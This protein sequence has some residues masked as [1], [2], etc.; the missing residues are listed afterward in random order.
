MTQ[1]LVDDPEPLNPDI[2]NQQDG[3]IQ[4]PY[5]WSPREYQTPAWMYF[6]NGGKRACICWHRRSGK[7]LFGINLIMNSIIQ[8]PGLYWHL[9]PYNTQAKKAIWNGATR[10]GRPF[11]S[12]FPKALVDKTRED[13]MLVKFKPTVGQD[14]KMRETGGTYQL[15]GVDEPDRLVGPNPVGVIFSEWSLMDPRVWHLIKPI[16][17]ENG[18]WALFIFTMRG[19]NHAYK[20][21]DAAKEK[22]S[23]FTQLL[24]V[25]DTYKLVPTGEIRKNKPV[26]VARPLITEEMIQEDRDEGI[27]ESTIQAE[28]YGNADAPVEGS[29]YGAIINWLEK[30]LGRIGNIP[31]DPKLPVHTSWDIGHDSTSITFFQAIGQELRIIDFYENQGEGLPHYVSILKEKQKDYGYMYELHF[32][33][34]DIEQREWAAGGKSKIATARSLG[35]KLITVA[36]HT[37]EDGIEE[38]RAMLKRCWFDRSKCQYLLE[39]LREYCK[40]WDEKNKVFK[41]K[42]LH[43]WA[44]HPADSIRQLAMGFRIRMQFR[45]N[46]K[47]QKKAVMDY[48]DL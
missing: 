23:W 4:V 5:N 15:M 16:L 28:Y 30:Q 9:F 20:M 13:D 34:H 21:M 18:G 36:H 10:D 29:Y 7:D 1:D 33:P 48:R 17:N 24:T 3:I 40:E 39:A 8:R 31:H 6:Q 45:R 27:P 41:E 14:G 47:V 2:A 12:H 19:R 11:L 43:N 26:Y 44:S 22:K 42:P 38:T 25:K 32:A 37:L 46:R 35:L